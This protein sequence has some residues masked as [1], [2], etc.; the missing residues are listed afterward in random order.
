M[1]GVMD[2]G[3]SHWLLT[4]PCGHHTTWLSRS[5]VKASRSSRAPLRDLRVI[6]SLTGSIKLT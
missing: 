4:L 6:Y 1:R 5:M 3:V 2:A